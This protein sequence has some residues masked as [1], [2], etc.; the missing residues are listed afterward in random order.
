VSLV[1]NGTLLRERLPLLMELPPSKIGI[2]L[3]AASSETHDRLRG[4]EGAW[5]MTVDGIE[6]AVRT[7]GTSNPAVIS[8]LFPSRRSNL[9]AM[10]RF[11][12]ALGI[13]HWIVNPLTRVGRDRTG[14]V[15]GDRIA[16]LRDMLR[17]H[18][19]S[20][21]A[22]IRLTLDDEFDCL[23]HEEAML[24]YPE[25]L[26]LPFRV[27]PERVH[28]VRMN[29]AGECTFGIDILR[30]QS[31]TTPRWRP[32]ADNAAAFLSNIIAAAA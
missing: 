31:A 26:G 7:L 29:P 10:P 24:K 9:D 4:V 23:R 32:A 25:F 6:A 14:G 30:R 17:L 16:I 13:K 12:A 1:T 27:L 28:I 2:S 19:A 8:I 22:G 21:E 20:L 15:I 11:L 3:D 18:E 5:R